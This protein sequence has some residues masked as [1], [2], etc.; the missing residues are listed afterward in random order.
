MF[1]WG[2]STGL[3]LDIN[4]IHRRYSQAAFL[5]CLLVSWI[6]ALP[7][8]A[9]THARFRTVFGDID[10][11]LMDQDKPVTVA[12]F[13]RYIESGR[14]TNMFFHR[15]VPGFVVQGGGF[16][17][18]NRGTAEQAMVA[19]RSFGTITNEFNVGPKI[20]NTRG[21]IAMAKLAGNPNSASSQWFFNFADNSANLDFQNGGFT[22]FGR[23]IRGDDVLQIL[24]TFSNATRATNLVVNAGSPLNQLP[25]L[26][27]PTDDESFYAGLVFVDVTLLG[28]D[29]QRLPDGG[30][31]ISWEAVPDTLNV[32]EYTTVLPPI[33][34]TLVELE[35]P[36]PGRATFLDASAEGFRFYRVR[37]PADLTDVDPE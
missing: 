31:E 34:E 19:V 7:S 3:V 10:V 20:S 16:G 26:T 25:Q 33:W 15:L 21:T 28:V 8:L 11:D 14:Y 36:P 2:Q 22:V 30:F 5:L 23:T 32:I 18:T 9:G 37:V 1:N 12:N 27:R 24:S 13:K 17:V 29:V 4:R 6:V 35:A